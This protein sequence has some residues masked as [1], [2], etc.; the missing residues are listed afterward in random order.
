MFCLSGKSVGKCRFFSYKIWRI[1][2]LKWIF[3][4]LV[5]FSIVCLKGFCM[6]ISSIYLEAGISI[7][8]S[9]DFHQTGTLGWFSLVVKVSVWGWRRS[10]M[11]PPYVFF[12]PFIGPRSHDNLKAPSTLKWARHLLFF[13]DGYI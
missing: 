4:T 2:A 11:S 5:L 7:K 1:W 8:N 9:L 12:R 3:V 10:I 13:L 6:K